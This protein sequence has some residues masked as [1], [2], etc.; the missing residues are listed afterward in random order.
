MT[1]ARAALAAGLLWA[2]TTTLTA[3]PEPR[4]ELDEYMLG[5]TAEAERQGKLLPTDCGTEDFAP[6]VC[7]VLNLTARGAFAEAAAALLPWAKEPRS[8]YVREQ[9]RKRIDILTEWSK[10]GR[11]D[12]DGYREFYL[13]MGWAMPRK[14]LQPIVT[15]WQTDGLPLVEK[16]FLLARLL[17]RAEEVYGQ[18]RV[19]LATAELPEI[20]RSE[21]ARALLG[22]GDALHEFG[23]IVGAQIAWYS[24]RNYAASRQAWPQAVLNLAHLE[25][26][27]A[28]YESAIEYFTEVL[29]SDPNDEQSGDNLMETNKN[30]SHRSVRGISRC[31]EA[32]G[33]Y[34]QALHYAKLARDEYRFV[35]W[36]G[37]CLGS[38]KISINLRIAKL[39]ALIYGPHATGIAGL[40]VFAALLYRRRRKRR[41]TSVEDS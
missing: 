4:Q 36:C 40:L 35:S 3:A 18:A 6:A 11:I 13:E 23:D 33:N 12:I 9:L 16:H 19:L 10:E 25:E 22:A 5:L 21:G 27:A 24:V 14:R 39:G 30:Y 28:R 7:D 20:G 8:E 2:H 32:L 15:L 17:H 29:A 38:A 37:T 41:G 31:H 1:P 26:R 34:G